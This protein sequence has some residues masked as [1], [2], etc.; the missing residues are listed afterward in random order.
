M[1][2]YNKVMLTI[3]LIVTILISFTFYYFK[4]EDRPDKDTLF[5]NKI[6]NHKSSGT[7]KTYGVA[8]NNAIATRVGNKIIEDGGNAVDAA[9]GVSY[10]LAV[11]EPHSSGLGGGGATL[12]YD[13][14]DGEEPK[15]YEYKTMSSFNYKKGDQIGTPGF[16]QGL[17]DMH[18][19]EGKMD[20]KKVFNYVIPL[21]EDGFEVDAELERSLKM[22][23]SDI[24]RDS[25][26][27][28]G[29]RTVREGDV[30]KQEDLAETLR[31]I[32]DD[33]TGYFYKD[34]GKSISK[35]LDGELK[36]D[37]FKAF[38]TEEKKPVSTKYLNNTVYA[39]SN[40]LG[41]TLMLQGL[42]IDESVD[43]QNNRSDFISGI[44]KSRDVMY[45]NR[46]IVNGQEAS[47][48]THLSQDYLSSRLNS[49]NSVA[50]ADNGSDFNTQQID[51]TST[52]HFVV[53]DKNGKLA[54]TTNTLS[55]FFG[56]GKFVKEGFYMNNSLTNF[57]NDP[58]SPNYGGK[59][60]APR[61][62][63]S[64]T[65]VVGPDFY[66]GIGTPGGNKIPTIL[67]EVIIDYL[68]GNGTLQESIDKPRFYNDGGTVY[69]ENAMSDEDINEF[70]RL[71]Y[72]V[73][74]KRND[75]N[76]G[77]IQ[78]AIYNK[79]DHTVELGHDVGNR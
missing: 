41:G 42:K 30:V 37:D 58:N 48:D 15:M 70:K 13:G 72:G 10:A 73:Q 43:T 78:G 79:N 22:F 36:E 26:F 59:H 49:I 34:I 19:R 24:D 35:Q 38:K 23:G 8:S 7:K 54:S 6:T 46:D 47:S 51:N 74:E 50:G 17:H 45:R 1:N 76:F 11:T 57:S 65:I 67:N 20:E 56:S 18:E 33:G 9:M 60:K 14:K 3:I 32:R 44:I 71:N 40:P 68:R 12:T 21:A 53:I 77:S 66:M 25:P 55:S 31:K 63:T 27:F 28:K 64:P 75:P 4:K 62:F 69:Y 5:E 2:I 29:K 61:S 39:A 16:V 52:T